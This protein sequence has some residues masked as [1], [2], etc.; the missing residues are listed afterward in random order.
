M[1]ANTSEILLL[2]LTEHK[3]EYLEILYPKATAF[4][5]VET[6][7]EIEISFFFKIGLYNSGCL[8]SFYKINHQNC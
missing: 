8:M 6:K 4:V 2:N 3:L 1:Y 5:Q 7:F